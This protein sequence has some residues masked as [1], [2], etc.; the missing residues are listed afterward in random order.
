VVEQTRLLLTL[1]AEAP[2]N[3]DQ[4]IVYDAI[5]AAVDA[6]SN[7]EAPATFIFVKGQGGCGKTTIAKKIMAYT[8]STGNVALGCASTGLAAALYE[9]F[10]TAHGLFCYP[11]VEEDEKDESEPGQCELHKTRTAVN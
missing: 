3:E 8:R 11:V 10:Y 2:N 4:Q 7:S 5:T 6:I 1:N 9:D